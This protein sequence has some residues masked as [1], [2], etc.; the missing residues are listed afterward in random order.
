[1]LGKRLFQ[2]LHEYLRPTQPVIL[3]LL[4]F[5]IMPNI[6]CIKYN[7]ILCW[8][9]LGALQRKCIG[10]NNVKSWGNSKSASFAFPGHFYMKANSPRNYRTVFRKSLAE[11]FVQQD[12]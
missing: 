6:I 7:C 4:Q 9:Y 3:P 12:L 1:M 5:N 2:D 8:A 10:L 11:F